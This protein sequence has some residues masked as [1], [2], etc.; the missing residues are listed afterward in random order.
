MDTN[1]VLINA[2]DTY[3]IIDIPDLKGDTTSRVNAVLKCKDYLQ[4]NTVTTDWVKRNWVIMS[5]AVKCYRKSLVDDIHHARIIED[6]E[7]L[8]ELY[9]EY[10]ILAPY[11]ELFKKFPKFL[12]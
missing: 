9:A 3:L 2:L 4:H 7:S 5:P 1:S 11:I 12:Q 10:D 8:A 6:E